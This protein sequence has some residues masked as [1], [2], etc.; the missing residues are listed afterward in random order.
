MNKVLAFILLFLYVTE[1]LQEAALL[2]NIDN[3][4]PKAEIESIDVLKQIVS[5]FGYRMRIVPRPGSETFIQK[6][7]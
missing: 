3:I 2:C 4:H 6:V 7:R 1:E 5:K